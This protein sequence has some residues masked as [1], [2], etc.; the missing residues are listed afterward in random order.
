MRRFILFFAIFLFYFTNV[1]G[2]PKSWIRINQLGYK[3]ESAK[4]AVWCGKEKLVNERWQLADAMTHEIVFTARAG[5]NFGM[6]GPF[7]DTYR[8]D[9]SSFK[10]TGRYYLQCG[11]TRSP[12]FEIGNDVY[13]GAADFCL[14]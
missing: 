3:P 13:K 2:Q 5:K 8:F 1:Q 4:V 12:E 7:S 11:A 9:F 10:K 6:Y 14:R